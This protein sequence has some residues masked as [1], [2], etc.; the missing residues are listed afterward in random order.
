MRYGEKVEEGKKN[1]R[2]P[3]ETGSE[4]RQLRRRSSLEGAVARR[5]VLVD[6]PAVERKAPRAE[7]VAH[8]LLA[9]DR[10]RLEARLGL[11]AAREAADLAARERDLALRHREEAAVPPEVGQ[12]VEGRHGRAGAHGAG[13]PGQLRRGRR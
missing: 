6:R 2:T 3:A 10:A 11:E 9:A 1:T 13:R 12:H 8:V 4:E 5:F 7:V